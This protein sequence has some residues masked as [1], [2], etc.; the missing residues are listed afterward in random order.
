MGLQMA[1]NTEQR[2]AL[3]MSQVTNKVGLSK[4]HIYRLINLGL[5]PRGTR[6]S[7]RVVIFDSTA[8]DQW[9]ASKFEGAR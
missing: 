9:L 1:I 6:L 4:A 8:I 2:R 7:E 3:R 5:F